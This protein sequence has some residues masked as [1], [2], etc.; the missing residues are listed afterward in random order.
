MPQSNEP[1]RIYPTFRYR[2]AAAMIAWLTTIFG[3]TVHASYKDDGG[4]VQHAELA[5]GSAMVML[6]TIAEDGYG[7]MVGANVVPGA[8]STYVVVDDPDVLFARAKAA[9]VAILEGLTERSYGSREFVVR[10]PEGNVWCFGTYWP[11]AGEAA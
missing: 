9:G 5:Y 2:D 1:P 6:G 4:A 11:K 8:K 3:F 7:A 10:D